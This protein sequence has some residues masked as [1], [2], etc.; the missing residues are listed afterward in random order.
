MNEIHIDTIY[1]ELNELQDFAIAMKNTH[2]TDIVDR[3][4]IDVDNISIFIKNLKD[5][6]NL[7]KMKNTELTNAFDDMEE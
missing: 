6:N 3:L 2:L 7:L 4:I 5:E 1:S